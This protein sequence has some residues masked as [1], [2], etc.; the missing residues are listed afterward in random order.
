MSNIPLCKSK[1]KVLGNS[2]KFTP[3]PKPNTPEVK[4]DMQDFTRKISTRDMYADE[5]DCKQNS[6]DLSY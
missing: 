4:Y 3:T 2:L 6:Q 1:T 5:N